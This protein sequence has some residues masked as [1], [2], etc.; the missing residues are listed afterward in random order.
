MLE[1]SHLPEEVTLTPGLLAEP[2]V[3]EATHTPHLLVETPML[4]R[5]KV[6]Q[7]TTTPMPRRGER[8]I[9]LE[10]NCFRVSL[11]QRNLRQR[12]SMGMKGERWR[13]ISMRMRRLR[14]SSRI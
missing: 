2:R 8:T 4:K 1:P 10:M 13:R 5:L 6:E 7:A 11:L 14:G 3:V 9:K 12:E